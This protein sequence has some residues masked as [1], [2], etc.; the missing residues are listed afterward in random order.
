MRKGYLLLAMVLALGACSTTGPMSGQT[1]SG[2]TGVLLAQANEH[3]R[4]GDIDKSI[5]LVERAV[6]IEP[7]NAF[8]WHRLAKLHFSLN[9]FSKAEQFARR[10]IQFAGGNKRLIQDNQRLIET[11]RLKQQRES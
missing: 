7:R 4:M 6:R 10:S 8:A 9:N 1:V 2:P 5:A 3:E 11:V